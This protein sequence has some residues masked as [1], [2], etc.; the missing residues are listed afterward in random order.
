MCKGKVFLISL[1]SLLFLFGCSHNAASNTVNTDGEQNKNTTSK[2]DTASEDDCTILV[3]GKKIAAGDYVVI[4]EQKQNAE[5]PVLAILEALGADVE[6]TQGGKVTI[7]YAGKTFDMDTESD[8]FGFPIPPG[9]TNAVRKCIN[10]EIL[11]DADSAHA[12]LRA[13]AATMQIDYENGIISVF[14]IDE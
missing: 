4:N 11:M 7:R 8:D 12:L 10:Q 3:S 9:T 1:M 13:F 5:I 6:R 2:E 14:N